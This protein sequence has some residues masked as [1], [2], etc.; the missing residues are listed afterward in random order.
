ML[1]K[2]FSDLMYGCLQ[3]F[4]VDWIGEPDPG[5]LFFSRPSPY[6]SLALRECLCVFLDV[7][8]PGSRQTDRNAYH[9]LHFPRTPFFLRHTHTRL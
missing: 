6:I 4:L 8:S 7:R 1:A 2:I 9:I 3:G 5:H